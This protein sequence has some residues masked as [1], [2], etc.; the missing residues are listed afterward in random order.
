MPILTSSPSASKKVAK[1]HL[2]ESGPEGVP[3][4]RRTKKAVPR[5]EATAPQSLPLLDRIADAADEFLRLHA[6]TL[7]SYRTHA[8]WDDW[9]GRHRE[10]TTK[11]PRYS[12]DFPETDEPAPFLSGLNNVDYWSK[13][14]GNDERRLGLVEDVLIGLIVEASGSGETAESPLDDSNLLNRM[15]NLSV[16]H[17][18]MTFMVWRDNDHWTEPDRIIVLNHETQL[19]TGRVAGDQAP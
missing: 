15:A 4:H 6:L 10:D 17:R 19:D 2:A 7:R 8:L 14:P 11:D 18:G 12:E 3:R 1:I 16:R 5:P 9:A 13:R